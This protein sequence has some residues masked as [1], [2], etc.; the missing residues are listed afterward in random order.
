MEE[1]E[2]EDEQ[3]EFEDERE[4]RKERGK[5]TGYIKQK[6]RVCGRGQELRGSVWVW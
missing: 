3:S 2:G 6:V 5:E 1:E 4:T